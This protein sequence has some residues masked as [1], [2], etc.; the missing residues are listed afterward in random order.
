[1]DAGIKMGSTAV[2]TITGTDTSA[3]QAQLDSFIEKWKTEGVDTVYI[4][5]LTASAKQF[6]EKIKAALPKAQLIADSDSVAEQA[7]DEVK[8]ERTPNP[9]EGL[10]AT[11]GETAA[12]RWA[13]KSPQLQQCVNIYEKAPGTK[14]PAPGTEAKN[15]KGKTIEPATAVTDFCG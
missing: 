12:E 14:A 4:A 1:Q 8:A 3:A 9:N 6:V 5:G 15:A 2:L 11:T 10:L 13:N 7:Q